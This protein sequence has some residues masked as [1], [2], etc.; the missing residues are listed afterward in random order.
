MIQPH[1][2]SRLR[3]GARKLLPLSLRRAFTRCV[4]RLA[5]RKQ[6]PG[7]HH[8]HTAA[9]PQGQHAKPAPLPMPQAARHGEVR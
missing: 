7:K 4:D 5:W 6:E 1:G 8:R 3:R 9:R 2:L